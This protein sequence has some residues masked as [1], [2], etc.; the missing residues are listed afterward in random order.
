MNAAILRVALDVP[1]RR[2]FDYLPPRAGAALI[3]PGMRVRVPFGQPEAGGFRGGTGGI[4]GAASRE[5]E[6]RARSARLPRRYSIRPRSDSSNGLPSTTTTRSAKRW[7]RRYPRRCG[8]GRLPWRGKSAGSRLS[9]GAEAQSRGEP[10]RAPKQRAL[11]SISPEQD[12]A[13][14]QAL[15][16]VHPGLAR[17]GARAGQARLDR[18]LRARHGRHGAKRAFQPTCA[19]AGPASSAQNSKPRLRASTLRSA[20]LPRSCFTASRAAARPRCICTWSSKCSREAERAL[21]LVPEIGLT[22]QLVGRFSERFTVPLAVLHSGLTDLERLQ[23]W[24]AAFSGRGAHRARHALGRICAGAAT[25][26]HRRRRG[27]RRFVQTARRRLSL[28]G[29]GSRSAARAARRRAHRAGLR[30]ACARNAAQLNA[31]RYTQLSL[32]RRTAQAQP[33]RMTLDRSARRRRAMRASPFPP[34]RRSSAI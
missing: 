10:A 5:A 11:L 9:E 6:T 13:S 32:P 17:S 31:G 33:P 4:V 29:T 26:R 30:D 12:G 19:P 18:I 27:A 21:V 15:N 2:L 3:E 28:L 34:C 24:R 25:R 22:P 16:A 1:L 20:S 23:A 14:A 8:W 7:P